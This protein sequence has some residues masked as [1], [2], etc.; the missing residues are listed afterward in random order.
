V[1]VQIAGAQK[2]KEAIAGVMMELLVLTKLYET[3]LEKAF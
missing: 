1:S 2:V 3:A